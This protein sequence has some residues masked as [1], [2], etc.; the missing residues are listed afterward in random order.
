MTTTTQ[1]T[2]QERFQL[3]NA[4]DNYIKEKEELHTI[5][6]ESELTYDIDTS[7]MKNYE[8][9]KVNTSGMTLGEKKIDFTKKIEAFKAYFDDNFKQ[10][11]KL[12]RQYRSNIDSINKDLEIQTDKLLELKN[13]RRIVS[14]DTTTNIRKLK[15]SKREL[16]R[17][18]YYQHLYIIVGL[19]QIINLLILG[20]MYSKTIPKLTGLIITFISILILTLYIIYYIYFK[21]QTRDTV[22]FNKFKFKIDKEYTAKLPACPADNAKKRAAEDKLLQD[23]INNMIATTEGECEVSLT[24]DTRDDYLDKYATTSTAPTPTPTPTATTST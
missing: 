14:T 4:I 21:E 3:Q 16:E 10:N 5:F 9:N 2:A 12:L 6:K 15:E 22:S 7:G 8:F 20:L 19:T 24:D 23:K 11:T 17:Q 18:K 13:I 1:P